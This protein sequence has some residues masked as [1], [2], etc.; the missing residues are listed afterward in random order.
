MIPVLHGYPMDSTPWVPLLDPYPLAAGTI[1][2]RREGPFTLL[3]VDSVRVSLTPLPDTV[4]GRLPP[5]HEVDVS[6]ISGFTLT[7]P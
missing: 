4:I 3:R 5:G 6:F 1:R 2:C 7:S